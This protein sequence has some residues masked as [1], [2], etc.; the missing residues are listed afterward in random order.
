MASL[1]L[2]IFPLEIKEIQYGKVKIEKGVVA[3]INA[4][5]EE[6]A[7]MFIEKSKSSKVIQNISFNEKLEAPVQK[8]SIIGEV[9]YSVDDKVVKKVNII[10]EE[11][12]KKL[13]LINMTTNLYETWF[14]LLR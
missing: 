14:N 12:V 10:A 6:N 8:G 9:T 2:Q 11:E 4:V 1:I 3:E 13:N 5:L 7:S